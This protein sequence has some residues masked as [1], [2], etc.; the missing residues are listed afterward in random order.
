MNTQLDLL[1]TNANSVNE[2]RAT[3]E[4]HASGGPPGRSRRSGYQA[5]ILG[6]GT[7]FRNPFQFQ[8]RL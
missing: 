1:N 3:F 2:P 4:A 6:L 8:L 7:G 5:F